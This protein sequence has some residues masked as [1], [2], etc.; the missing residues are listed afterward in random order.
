MVINQKT[1]PCKQCLVYPICKQR[2]IQKLKRFYDIDTYQ[3]FDIVY[4][5]TEQVIH[6]CNYLTNIFK[7]DKIKSGPNYELY[8]QLVYFFNLIEIKDSLYE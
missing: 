6:Q 1:L 3:T 7:K 8:D 2:A 5:A 4:L